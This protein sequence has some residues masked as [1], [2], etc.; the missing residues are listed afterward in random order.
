[1]Q[2]RLA[3]LK[4]EGHTPSSTGILT[5]HTA[6]RRLAAARSRSATNNLPLWPG[7]RVIPEVP[8]VE[9]EGESPQGVDLGKRREATSFA[10][11]EKEER[12]SVGNEDPPTRRSLS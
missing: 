5:L 10:K 11:V 7:S 4:P 9:I 8:Q 6:A 12:K 3:S 2:G 1:M